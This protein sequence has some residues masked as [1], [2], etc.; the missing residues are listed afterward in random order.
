MGVFDIL[1]YIKPFSIY[2][3]G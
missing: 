1:T 3:T 2:C